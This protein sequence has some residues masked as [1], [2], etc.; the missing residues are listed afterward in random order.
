[1]NCLCS[2]FTK[3]AKSPVHPTTSLKEMITTIS[4]PLVVDKR[5]LRK[6]SPYLSL[7]RDFNLISRLFK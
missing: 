1:M 2:L 3:R 7:P 6:I 5:T 4:V